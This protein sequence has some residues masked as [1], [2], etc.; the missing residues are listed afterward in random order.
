MK[1][2]HTVW[3]VEMGVSFALIYRN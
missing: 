3:G 2:T 1:L